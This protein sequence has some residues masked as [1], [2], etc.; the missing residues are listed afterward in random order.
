[1]MEA[2]RTTEWVYQ[3]MHGVEVEKSVGW[4]PG[5]DCRTACEH[6]KKGDHGQHVDEL[7]L[8]L[9]TVDS[10]RFEDGL[11]VSL[12]TRT[13]DREYVIPRTNE[14]PP[15]L[16]CFHHSYIFEEELV[17]VPKSGSACDVLRSGTC[18]PGYSSSMAARDIWTPLDD[19][20]FGDDV[21]AIDPEVR[22]LRWTETDLWARMVL[23]LFQESNK[24]RKEHERLP[25]QCHH[26]SGTG[27]RYQKAKV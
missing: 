14:L 7:W 23:A 17:R 12:F 27:L 6:E 5:F 3:N 11:V 26:C 8:R 24:R 19:R 20:A 25:S 10:D 21:L 15:A 4:I 2:K 1:M 9:R 18:F 22:L 13:R 16:L